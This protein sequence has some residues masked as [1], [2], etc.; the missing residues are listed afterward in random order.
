VQKSGNHILL[1]QLML[2]GKGESVNAAKCTIRCVLDESFDRA[3]RLGFGQ[4]P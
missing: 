4:F 2:N 3:D 1:I